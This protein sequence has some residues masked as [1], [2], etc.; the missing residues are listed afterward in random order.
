MILPVIKYEI[1]CME[2]SYVQMQLFESVTFLFNNSQ[3]PQK[4]Y[5]IPWLWNQTLLPQLELS[6]GINHFPATFS[7]L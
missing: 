5:G 6:I 3:L 1:V 7:Y 4:G 2:S